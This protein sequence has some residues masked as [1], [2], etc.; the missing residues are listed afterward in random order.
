VGPHY[1]AIPRIISPHNYKF[2]GISSGDALVQSEDGDAQFRRYF[3]ST[4]WEINQLTA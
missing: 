1:A 3:S 4:L 2:L